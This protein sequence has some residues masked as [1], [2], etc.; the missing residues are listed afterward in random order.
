MSQFRYTI[1]NIECNLDTDDSD[2]DPEVE[3]DENESKEE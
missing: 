3:K 2:Y 1:D